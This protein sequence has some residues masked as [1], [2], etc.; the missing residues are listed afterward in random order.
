M[1][2]RFNTLQTLYN[3]VKEAQHPELYQCTAREMILHSTFNWE[4]IH[5]H[6]LALAEEE[7]I[8]IRQMDPLH[9]SIT[10]KGLEVLKRNQPRDAADS[11]FQLLVKPEKV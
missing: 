4:L 11:L 1:D 2:N 10:L 8:Y 5:K 7:L 9:F 3:I 6:L